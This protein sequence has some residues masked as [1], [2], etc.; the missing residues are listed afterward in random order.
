MSRLKEKLKTSNKP[1]RG[2]KAELIK[3]L[4]GEEQFEDGSFEDYDRYTGPELVEKLKSQN[5]DIGGA[6]EDLINRL[7]GKEPPMP[8]EGWAHS[9][10]QALLISKFRDDDDSSFRFM[11]AEQVHK[12][13][14][15]S[16]WPLYRFREYFKN[17]LTS[18]T[19]DETIAAQDNIDFAA[20]AAANPVSERDRNGEPCC[21]CFIS[22]HCHSTIY[23]W[24]YLGN[25]RWDKHIASS[26]L[27]QDVLDLMEGA[28]EGGEMP[29]TKDIWK[30]RDEYMWFPLEKFSW[31]LAAMKRYYRQ[32]PG[33]QFR[34]NKEAKEDYENDVHE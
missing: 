32:Y 26:L 1:T 13:E 19:R 28:K 6:R 22:W 30:S 21:R 34:R 16:R 31:H 15:F 2:N 27:K 9:K 5:R 20:F 3:R 8:K 4:R 23:N 17:A 29:L 11:T 7:M 10:D 18:F 14:P 12:H 25:L 24:T 33:W